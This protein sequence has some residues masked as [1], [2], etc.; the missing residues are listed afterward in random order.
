[1]D[2]ALPPTGSPSPGRRVLLPHRLRMY[3]AAL[4]GVI[5]LVVHQTLI[6]SKTWLITTL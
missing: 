2:A 3:Q 6:S 5:F 1:M 4:V